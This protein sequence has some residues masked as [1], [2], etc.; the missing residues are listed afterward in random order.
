MVRTEKYKLILYPEVK[1]VQLFDLEKDPWEIDKNNLVEDS[2]NSAT[3]SELFR[4]LKQWQAIVNDELVLDPASF[5]YR[6]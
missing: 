1:K 6:A 2:A 4:Q 5:R 3:I